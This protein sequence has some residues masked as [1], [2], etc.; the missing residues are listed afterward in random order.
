MSLHLLGLRGYYYVISLPMVVVGVINITGPRVYELFHE[1]LMGTL[2][3][4]DMVIC[5]LNYACRI[6]RCFNRGY[7]HKYV[8][9]LSKRGT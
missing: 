8:C 3:F 7:D 2:D 9:C 1:K 4:N 5:H 6:Y